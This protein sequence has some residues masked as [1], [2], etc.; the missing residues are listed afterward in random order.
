MLRDD[1][2]DEIIWHYY[3]AA[4]F[5]SLAA[6]WQALCDATIDSPLLSADFVNL[7]LAHFGHGDEL[8]CLGERNGVTVVGTIL[9]KTGP[10]AWQT[11]QPS[12]MPLGPWLQS[13]TESIANMAKGLL[14]QLPGP[15]LLL[16][17]TQ[18]DPDFYPRKDEPSLMTMDFITTGR[19]LLTPD[20]ATFMAGDTIKKNPKPAAALMRRMRKAIESYGMITLEVGTRAD[21]AR[22]FIDSYAAIESRGWK[23][24]EGTAL[25]PG[26]IQT[27][28]YTELLE[29]FATRGEARMYTLKFGSTPVA[30]QLA[31]AKGNA[32]VLLKT[33]YDQ[34]YRNFGPGVIQTYRIIESIINENRGFR[35][36]EIY[37]RFNDSQKLWV[38]ETRSIYHANAYR[39]PLLSKLHCIWI[40]HRRQNKE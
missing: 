12:Q 29:R 17:I 4:E 22:T 16:G 10:C 40:T 5:P 11:F 31:L 15:A 24:A 6:R 19:I 21:G 20:M 2:N 3:P 36:I 38:G 37:G 39:F 1:T 32:I 7:A 9:Q 27:S 34:N 30:H 8:V 13:P 35:V 28:F 33:T 14:R 26:D 23:G 18:L 25:V